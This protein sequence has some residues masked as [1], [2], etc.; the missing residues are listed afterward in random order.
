MSG[1][2]GAS[3]GYQAVD[4]TGQT[5]TTNVDIVVVAA[6]N[7]AAHR[8]VSFTAGTASAMQIDAANGGAG[9][10]VYA[11]PAS[12]ETLLSG[13][14]F[15]AAS[16]ELRSTTA[17]VETAST[18]YTLTATDENGASD[19]VSVSVIVIA[20][21]NFAEA[22]LTRA[23]GYQSATNFNLPNASDGVA[24]IA[25]SISAGNLPNGLAH[26]AANNRITGT[27]TQLNQ[28]TT[29][30]LTAT[31]A[32]GAS[33]NLTL[34]FDVVDAPKFASADDVTFTVGASKTVVLPTASGVGAVTYSLQ[35]APAWAHSRLLQ[36]RRRS[37]RILSAQ[38]PPAAMRMRP[39][40]IP[41][42][43]QANKRPCWRLTLWSPP[44][45]I[46]PRKPSCHIPPAPKTPSR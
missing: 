22:S 24:P 39:C 45:R 43:M 12:G 21:P 19:T 9:D 4:E 17:I 35:G 46:L 16:R 34:N 10:L 18:A 7:F 20:A 28:N 11:L 41:P 13:L 40:R 31:D 33:A 15:D 32:N 30:T 8:E 23:V 5:V 37:C 26:D 36:V 6:P 29:A 2:S 27:A 3:V 25:Y 42:P 1:D 44:R 14:T 38:P